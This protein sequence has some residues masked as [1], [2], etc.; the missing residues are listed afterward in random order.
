MYAVW[1]IVQ[2]S[3]W[4]ATAC[5]IWVFCLPRRNVWLTHCVMS[6]ETSVFAN[7]LKEENFCII[8]INPGMPMMLVVL[9]SPTWHHHSTP[10]FVVVSTLCCAHSS[11]G[12]IR[13]VGPSKVKTT[14]SLIHMSQFLRVYW[15][16]QIVVFACHQILVEYL[17]VGSNP[18]TDVAMPSPPRL[19]LWWGSLRLL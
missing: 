2:D 13:Y 1:Y 15:Y 12:A 14:C 7:A 3:K 19:L 18:K 17:C 8:A 16:L 6:A 11:P 4:K 9:V 10:A 5:N